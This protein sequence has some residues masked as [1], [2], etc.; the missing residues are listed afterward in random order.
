ALPSPTNAT[1]GAV[2]TGALRS[3]GGSAATIASVVAAASGSTASYTN[4]VV[5][6]YSNSATLAAFQGSITA[7]PASADA[8][9]SGA[10]V[11]ASLTPQVI[12]QWA[13]QNSATPGGADPK[14]IVAATI[15]AGQAYAVTI[16]T[17]AINTSTHTP[18]GNA[19]FGNLAYG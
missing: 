16:V 9:A 12:V 7:N 2:V 11:K 10:V 14:S 4:A 19:T 18:Y 5:A 17:G 3:Q 15:A 13:L 8:I 1:I 6:G